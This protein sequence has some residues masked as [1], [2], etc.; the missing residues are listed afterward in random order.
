MSL[1]ATFLRFTKKERWF[2]DQYS[3]LFMGL[4]PV[5]H[6]RTPST[7]CLQ[8]CM[9]LNAF[10]ES[11][12]ATKAA[13]LCIFATPSTSPKMTKSPSYVYITPSLNILH[14]VPGF[15]ATELQIFLGRGHEVTDGLSISRWLLKAHGST[16]TWLCQT[17]EIDSRKQ[18]SQNNHT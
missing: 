9:H 12:K 8:T 17:D 1:V 16:D 5:G 13:F 15:Q 7:S 6:F 2:R 4:G 10:A 11:Q 18:L 14:P 3:L